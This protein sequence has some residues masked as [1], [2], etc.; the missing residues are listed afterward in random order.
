MSAERGS[1]KH[2]PQMDEYQKHESEGAIRGGGPTH[3][4]EW[5]DPEGIRAADDDAV[6]RRYPPGHEPGAAEGISAEGVDQRSDMARWLTDADWPADRDAL[7]AHAD[8]K[9]APGGVIAV[10]RGLPAGEK[11]RNIGDVGRAAG[12][13]GEEHR[14]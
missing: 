14:F 8:A 6:P 1:A 12:L 7:L 2:G 4:E 5:A 9:A 3:A 10:L 11:F 13:G